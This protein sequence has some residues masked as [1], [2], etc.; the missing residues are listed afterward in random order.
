[1]PEAPKPECN[2]AL[3]EAEEAGLLGANIVIANRLLRFQASPADN[4]TS[5]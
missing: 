3:W 4:S 1:M 2:F 5:I